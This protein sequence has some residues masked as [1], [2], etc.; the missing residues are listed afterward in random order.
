[1]A[2][3][4]AAGSEAA[5]RTL[6][7]RVTPRLRGIAWHMCYDRHETEDLCQEA[8]LKLTSPA[9]LRGYR[10]EGPLD[11]YLSKVGVRAMISA[12]RVRHAREWRELTPVEEPPERPDPRATDQSARAHTLDPVLRDALRALPERSRLVVLMISVGGYSYEETAELTGI[13]LGTVKSSYSRAREALR[14]ALTSER[15]GR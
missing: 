5:L 14:R 6:L 2:R 4:A 11:A 15:V 13:A 9:A 8:L 3:A 12:R 7:G 1:M 10:G